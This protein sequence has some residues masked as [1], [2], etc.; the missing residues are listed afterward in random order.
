MHPDASPPP[1]P[2]AEVPSADGGFLDRRR[3]LQAVGATAGAAAVSAVPSGFADAAVSSGASR[4]VALPKAIR[5]ADTRE[6]IGHRFDP[7]D[8]SITNQYK[9]LA[10]NHIRVQ[11]R[12]RH[13][14][15]A[16]ASAVVLTVTGVATT[17]VPLFVTVYPTGLAR[18]EASNLNITRPFEANANLVFVKVGASNSVDIFQRLACSI[19]VDIVG[20]FEPTTAAVRDG[21]YMALAT[22]KRVLDTRNRGFKVSAGSSTVVDVTSAVPANAASV[23]VNLAAI[24]NENRG[25]YSA[26]PYSV[27]G[28]PT[29]STMNTVYPFDRRAGAAIVPVETVA[30]KRLFRVYAHVA[31]HILVDIAG[32]FTG[33]NAPESTQGLFVPTD[34]TRVLDTRVPDP[35]A[36]LWPNWVVEQRLPSPANLA[37]SVVINLTATATRTTGFL[38]V[39]GARLRTYPPTTSNVNWVLP[40]FTVPNLSVSAVT[41]THGIEVFTRSG[42]HIVADM[43]GY[44]TGTPKTA[45]YPKYINPPPPPVAPP[46]VLRVPR[47]GLTSFVLEGYSID[48]TNAGHSWHWTGTGNLGQVA[49]VSSFAH[50]TDAGSPYRYLHYL[51]PGDTWTLTTTD[52]REFTYRYAGRDLTDA[53]TPNILGATRRYPGTTFSMVACTRGWDSSGYRANLQWYE[54]TSL[55]WRLI[56]TGQLVSWRQV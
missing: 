8:S 14:V 25:F 37:A 34:P 46:W 52:G 48:I 28:R 30:G 5:L 36:K 47:L 11:V 2:E 19:V 18:P 29:T 40:N 50:R 42:G 45:R 23:L 1:Y 20:Y 24:D 22:P 21:R 15:P 17:S 13:D 27:S 56:V 55:K 39:D 41:E 3:F 49:H 43:A 44:F 51:Q 16:S 33:A 35:V 12:D 31:A 6:A 4:F 54:P 53:Q 26:V 9:R 7:S 32:Y 10:I 38:S